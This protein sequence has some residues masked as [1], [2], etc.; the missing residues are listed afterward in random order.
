MKIEDLPGYQVKRC[1]IRVSNPHGLGSIERILPANGPLV[2]LL[3][4]SERP[5]R[6]SR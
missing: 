2:V 4:T 6:R 1:R 5:K 3:L